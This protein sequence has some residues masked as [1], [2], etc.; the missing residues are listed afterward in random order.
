MHEA[1]GDRFLRTQR[2]AQLA[3]HAPGFVDVH[4]LAH[5][6]RAV[7]VIAAFASLGQPAHA[8]PK[9]LELEARNFPYGQSHPVLF[10]IPLAVPPDRLGFLT[11]PTGVG[12]APPDIILCPP[13]GRGKAPDKGGYARREQEVP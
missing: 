6:R 8:P 2:T 10:V 12:I 11:G 9:Q 3:Q 5:E 13:C 7:A 4:P 1:R